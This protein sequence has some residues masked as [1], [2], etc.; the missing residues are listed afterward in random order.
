MSSLLKITRRALTIGLLCCMGAAI[1][2]S[3]Q[4]SAAHEYF[5][6]VALINQDGQTMRFYSD[7]LQ[8]NVVV[9]NT[10]SPPVKGS[11]R[12]STGT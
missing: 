8:G 10:F 3:A 5:T 7:V 1:S 2:A 6:D 9:I 11:A 12:S 4:L